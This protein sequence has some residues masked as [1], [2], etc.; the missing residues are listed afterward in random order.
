MIEIAHRIIGPLEK[1]S[2][3]KNI[4]RSLVLVLH[5]FLILI[6]IFSEHSWYFHVTRQKVKVL[7][8][9]EGS[10]D[11][12]GN[13]KLIAGVGRRT[14]QPQPEKASDRVNICSE[15]LKQANSEEAEHGPLLE[16]MVTRVEHIQY[17]H[18]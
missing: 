11:W 17:D 6:L 13:L 18:E 5:L 14:K 4:W 9:I 7:V 1:V 2:F 12:I 15:G 10:L 8:V 3:L 16:V